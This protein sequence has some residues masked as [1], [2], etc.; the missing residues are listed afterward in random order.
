MDIREIA[1]MWKDDPEELIHF[2]D[3]VVGDGTIRYDE[4]FDDY[5]DRIFFY[6]NDEAEFLNPNTDEDC[7]F[8][9]M[10]VTRV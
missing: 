1:Y 7:P 3:V 9:V 10:S 6:Y 4:H 8:L 2:A 5:D